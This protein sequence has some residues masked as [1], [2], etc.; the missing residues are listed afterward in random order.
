MIPSKP[1][2]SQL[3]SRAWLIKGLLSPS[4]GQHSIAS[5]NTFVNLLFYI[6][7]SHS[8]TSNTPF[9][10]ATVADACIPFT[11]HT[12][13]SYTLAIMCQQQTTAS[14]RVLP[15]NSAYTKDV[16]RYDQAMGT[17]PLPATFPAYP[18]NQDRNW[19]RLYKGINPGDMNDGWRMSDTRMHGADLVQALLDFLAT[20]APYAPATKQAGDRLKELA[21]YESSRWTPD[22]V[23]KAF[24]DLDETFFGGALLGH[25]HLEWCSK[26]QLGPNLTATTTPF[27]IPI[28]E[29]SGE[30]TCKHAFKI[31]MN[32]SQIFLAPLEAGWIRDVHRPLSRWENMWRTLV[33][34]MVHCYLGVHKGFEYPDH[35]GGDTDPGHGVYFQTLNAAVSERFQRIFGFRLETCNAPYTIPATP[36]DRRL[37]SLWLKAYKAKRR[38]ALEKHAKSPEEWSQFFAYKNQT[39]IRV[40]R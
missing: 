34:E 22:I 32:A 13:T 14:T 3:I 16:G 6:C 37:E 21:T 33:H 11:V 30:I 25:V 27:A 31:Q 5:S 15:A 28:R 18:C 7:I 40:R 35:R 8:F 1:C 26:E 10:S 29:A 24:D 4:V 12:T 23:F 20:P 2:G 9:V 39:N 19:M 38:A 17:L 36:E